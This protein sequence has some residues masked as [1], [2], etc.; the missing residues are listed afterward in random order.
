MKKSLL[1]IVALMLLGSLSAQNVARECVLFE[2]FTGVNCPYCPAAANAI[3]QMMDEGLAIAPVAVHTSAFSTQDFY[4]N[5]TNARA[6][7]YG[8]TSYPTLKA[9]GITGVS[10]GGNASQSNYN[11]YINY[12]NNRISVSSPFTIDLSY[13]FVEGST[14]QVTAMVEKV[15]ECNAANLK[16]MIALT[17]SH[18]QKSWQGMSELN[19]VTR[20]FIPTQ[21]GT[22]FSGQSAIVTETFDMAGFPKEN[23][24]LVAWVQS[25]T[26][27]EVFQAVRISMEPENTQYDVALRSLSTIVTKNCS[28]LVE[29]T[30]T[31]KSFGS[32]HVDNLEIEVTD[33]QGNVL[34][35]YMWEGGISAGETV[36]IM[37]PEFDIQNA[38]KLNFNIKKVNGNDDAYPFDNYYSVNIQNADTYEGVLKFAVKSPSNAY[39][40]FYIV[41][42]N[43]TTNEIVRE[44]HFD[45]T[46]HAYQFTVDLPSDGCYKI[47]VINPNGTGSGTGFAK[48]TDSQNNTVM[49]FS[50]TINTFKYNYSVEIDLHTDGVG[51]AFAETIVAYPNPVSD[52]LN[53]DGEDIS[54]VEIY[55]SLGQNVY[56]NSGVANGLR[57]DVSA[58]ENGIYF[59]NIKKTNGESTSQKFVIKK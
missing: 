38:N 42:T 25:S 20:D 17:E 39:D 8:I 6:N 13:S 22:V 35:N 44:Q 16:V 53:I 54:Q 31:V 34:S 57:I 46:N 12:Y 52:I 55:N 23:M 28:G 1:T 43:M 10:G 21:N 5:E 26:T 37:M 51:D 18:I 29:P 2:I 7:F 45:Q 50:Q 24:H 19:A 41:I 9:D 33:N 32:E 14:C 48:V 11:S 4:T 56:T 58:F 47:S 30:L 49:Q 36:D 40:M 59:V 27:K 3:N 15:G